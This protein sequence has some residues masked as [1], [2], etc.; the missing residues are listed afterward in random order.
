MRIDNLIGISSECI[1]VCLDPGNGHSLVEKT[2]VA[3]DVVRSC[4]RGK[5]AENACERINEQVDSR[6]SNELTETKLN[7]SNDHVGG[8]HQMFRLVHRER[9][10]EILEVSTGDEDHHR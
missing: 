4:A 5:K 1:D 2:V 3:F 8:V 6:P 9:S 10:I 7:Q